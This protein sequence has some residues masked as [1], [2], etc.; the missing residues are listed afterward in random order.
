[1]DWASMRANK[2]TIGRLVYREKGEGKSLTHT[3]TLG[4]P[5]C[6]C[7]ISAKFLH[8]IFLQ[9]R[10]CVCLFELCDAS[11][12]NHVTY[13]ESPKTAEIDIDRT[14]LTFDAMPMLCVAISAKIL[15]FYLIYS[16][17]T[18]ISVLLFAAPFS[19]ATAFNFLAYRER[20]FVC[21]KKTKN[22]S[23]K[24]SVCWYSTFDTAH[25]SS[26][27]NWHTHLDIPLALP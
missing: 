27:T 9:I 20:F 15:P 3:H 7:T 5:I 12:A 11:T 1:M 13:G 26:K 2:R 22:S 25:R 18:A 17:L 4:Q 8:R 19:A 6:G 10:Q 21:F 16:R 24:V 14:W 23:T